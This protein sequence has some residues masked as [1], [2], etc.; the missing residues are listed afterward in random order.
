MKKITFVTQ[1]E[2]VDLGKLVSRYQGSKTLFKI[3]DSSTVKVTIFK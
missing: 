1:I 2:H 3:I